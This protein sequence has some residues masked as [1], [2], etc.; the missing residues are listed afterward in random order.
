MP[1]RSNRD[2]NINIRPLVDAFGRLSGRGQIIVIAIGVAGVIAFLLYQHHQANVISTAA[3]TDVNLLLGNPSNATAHDSDSNNYL[4][5]KPYFALSY[6]AANGTP[7][8]VSW[9]VTAADLGSAPRKQTFDTDATLP[10]SFYHVTHAD[11]SGSGFD[12]GHMCPH[13]DRQASTDM[14]YATFVMTNMIPQAPNVNRKAWDQLEIYGRELVRREHAHLYIVA[15]PA[16][17]GGV[18]SAGPRETIAHGSVVVP[19]E[20]WKIIVVVPEAGGEQDPPK[21][22]AATRVI[23]VIM[24]ND[25]TKVG[26]EWSGFRTPPAQIE[27]HTGLHFFSNLAPDIASALRQK[28]DTERIPAP[29]P[30][31]RE[32][33]DAR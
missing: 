5:L 15:G 3:A 10:A 19:A 31:N 4:M 18:G 17:R 14:S 9:R 16:G 28:I 2:D 6:N 21:I 12:R 27:S 24:P 20:C 1:R 30:F 13:G 8:W 23:A 11:Y 29:R 26:D 7:N 32:A 33:A 22:T 25:E